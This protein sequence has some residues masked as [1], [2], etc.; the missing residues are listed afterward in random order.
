MNELNGDR[1]PMYYDINLNKVDDYSVY[2]EGSGGFADEVAVF[3]M[4]DEKDDTYIKDVISK[5]IEQRKKDF[6]G[7][8]SWELDKIEKNQVS[9]EGKYV[10]FIISDNVD[11]AN[12]IFEGYFKK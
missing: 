4:K 2:I 8:N 6:T 11:K 1:I 10:C 12:N 9:E 3:K 5:R 7:Y